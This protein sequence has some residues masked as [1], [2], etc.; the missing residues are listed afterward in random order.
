MR[1]LILLGAIAAGVWS[2]VPAGKSA[3]GRDSPNPKFYEENF[4]L[5][6]YKSEHIIIGLFFLNQSLDR[7]ST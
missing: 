6:I 4:I 1:L 5:N 3:L 7:N 2:Q